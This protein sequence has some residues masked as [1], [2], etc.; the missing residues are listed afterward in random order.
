MFYMTEE[1]LGRTNRLHPFDTT[2]TAYKPRLPTT[3]RYRGNVFTELLPSN[4]RGCTD[5]PTDTDR[6]E[7]GV[8]NNS[9]IVA[10]L[11]VAVVT[12]LPTRCLAPNKE[13]HLTE[14]LSCNVRSD[15]H[16]ETRTDGRDLSSTLLKWAQLA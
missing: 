13:I 9:S 6:K 3:L 12:C 1:V 5:K 4:N 11:F 8:S 2:Q 15:P 10:C 14:P 7:S 16:R